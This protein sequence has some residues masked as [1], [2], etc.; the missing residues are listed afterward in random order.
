MRTYV[1][2]GRLDIEAD[3]A[4]TV[5]MYAPFDRKSLLYAFFL[6]CPALECAHRILPHLEVEK[7]LKNLRFFCLSS[8]REYTYTTPSES[9]EYGPGRREKRMPKPPSV[10]AADH[11]GHSAKRS[12]YGYGR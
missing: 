3:G 7:P 4:E 1:H 8:Q 9:R 11:S 5:C 12:R 2:H 10:V 6:A